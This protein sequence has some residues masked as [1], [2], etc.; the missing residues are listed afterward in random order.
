MQTRLFLI[1][2]T[3]FIVKHLCEV[4][5]LLKEVSLSIMSSSVYGDKETSVCML[6][7]VMTEHRTCVNQFILIIQAKYISPKN[8]NMKSQ[9]DSRHWSKAQ[10]R[11]TTIKCVIS[12]KFYNLEGGEIH[13]WD[14]IN[15]SHVLLYC[16]PVGI[17]T[18]SSVCLFR[19]TLTFLRLKFMNGF[20]N[21]AL[22]VTEKL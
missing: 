19:D 21:C 12:M 6:V 17:G 15:H 9:R 10:I 4:L 7:Y 5:H 22:E 14:L 1:Q 8:I 16:L 2:T 11:R 18:F 20:L 13:S 3:I